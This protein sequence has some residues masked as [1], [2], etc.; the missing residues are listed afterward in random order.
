LIV[1]RNYVVILLEELLLFSSAQNGV[2][3]LSAPFD[4]IHMHCPL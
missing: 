2:T 1:A 4:V 3:A